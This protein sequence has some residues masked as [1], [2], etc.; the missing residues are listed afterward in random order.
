MDTQSKTTPSSSEHVPTSKGKQRK[1]FKW[2]WTHK[3]LSFLLLA[4]VSISIW[5]WIKIRN[6]RIEFEKQNTELRA[7]Y[8]RRIDELQHDHMQLV[9]TTFSWAIRSELIRNNK[10]QIDLFF[11][12]FIHT[13]Q[14]VR[15][16]LVHPTSGRIEIST[17]EKDVGEKFPS[18]RSLTQQELIS[19]STTFQVLTPISGLNKN[20]GLFVLTA[21]F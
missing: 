9:A 7:S 20:L 21:K 10:E 11:A 1:F 12:E 18:F 14:V 3:L 13:P 15:L 5:S 17:D 8:D 16:Q 4:I 19:D 6:Q 2:A